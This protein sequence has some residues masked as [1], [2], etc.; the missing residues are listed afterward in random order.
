MVPAVPNATYPDTW[1]TDLRN[2]GVP[3]PTTRGPAWIQIG[4]E[5]GFLPAP[6]LVPNQPVDWNTDQ[7]T[8]DF[9][10]VNTHSLLLGTAER[11]D[12]IVDFSKFA[13]KTLILYND[14][15][16]AFPVAD[17]RLDYFTGNADQTDAGGAPSTIAGYG[18]NTR[19]VM[20][21]RV[22][23]SGGI[24]T[25]DDYN[26]AKLAALQTAWASTGTT[27]GVFARDQNTIIVPQAAYSSA[28]GTT[29]PDVWANI[30]DNSLTFTPVGSAT[31]VT[32][33]F[34]AKSMHDEMGGTFDAEYGRMS[35]TTWS[36]NSKVNTT[37]SNHYTIWLS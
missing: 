10:V 23:G 4:T 3:D 25:P 15:P 21:V 11:A 7:G 36:R 35:A 20:Q 14:A 22:S 24:A 28:Y 8:F 17:P 16:A 30:F 13:G 5:S 18:P 34:Q 1:P 9:G 32:I 19:T 33:P 12:V 37:N 27:Q 6:V 31:P 2:G 29:F 26:P